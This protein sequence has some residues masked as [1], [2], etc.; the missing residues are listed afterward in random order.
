ME[1]KRK[2]A[3]TQHIQNVRET[4]GRR[5]IDHM[6]GSTLFGSQEKKNKGVRWVGTRAQWLKGERKKKVYQSLPAK[7]PREIDIQGT[8]YA[9]YPGRV[10]QR[11]FGLGDVRK[12]DPT[13]LMREHKTPGTQ[14]RHQRL[15]VDDRRVFHA[16][17]R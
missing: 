13:H 6:Q 5:L 16:W 3:S 7:Y 10:H 12:D 17:V 4:N 15:G 11:K 1:R 2:Q 14:E 8:N 9:P